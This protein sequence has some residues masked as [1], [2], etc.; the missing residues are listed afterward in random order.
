MVIF[1][2]EF[3]RLFST[4]S[5]PLGNST[6]PS[7]ESLQTTDEPKV[8]TRA[9][10]TN[11]ESGFKTTGIASTRR[12]RTNAN[13]CSGFNNQCLSGCCIGGRCV[14]SSRCKP[15]KAAR[16]GRGGGRGGTRIRTGGGG[17]SGG[18]GGTWPVWAWGIFGGIMAL[19]IMLYIC[20]CMMKYYY[21]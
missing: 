2:N 14:D 21:S 3:Y 11:R 9:T 10:A 7:T 17:E 13:G 20:R 5:S 19:V 12:V 1:Y 15:V 6:Q 8:T 16:G 18:S 4:S